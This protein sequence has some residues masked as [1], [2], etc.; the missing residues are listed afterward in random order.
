MVRIRVHAFTWCMATLV[1]TAPTTVSAQQNEP[2]KQATAA[3]D[4]GTGA[5][6]APPSQQPP[7]RDYVFDMGEIVVVGQPGG[8][9]GRRR[10]GAHARSD[11]DLRSEHP[12]SSGQRGARCGQYLR[13]QRPPQRERHLR[14]RVR[15]MAGA[16]D[17]RR[18]AHLSAGGQSAR[19]QPVSDRGHRRS[20]DSEGL[21]VG[22]RRPGR[23]GRRHQSRDRRPTKS[24]RGRGAAAGW[25]PRATTKVGT[26][27]R[28]SARVSRSIYLQGSVE[29]FRSRLLDPVG[30]LSADAPRRCSPAGGV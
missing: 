8:T 12:R 20:P 26:A 3:P 1:V 10:R 18:R 22:A 2:S 24:V 4:Q 25:R 21:C 28:W 5:G 23:H 9:A 7:G 6:G 27:T 16:A 13:C 11:V 17:A 15:S 30:Q 19:L 14:A 29:L